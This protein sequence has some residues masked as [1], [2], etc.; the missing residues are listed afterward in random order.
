MPLDLDHLLSII[1]CVSFIS[2][3]ISSALGGTGNFGAGT[4]ILLAKNRNRRRMSFSVHTGHRL[5]PHRTAYQIKYIP[6]QRHS[7]KHP[8]N[9]R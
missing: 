9:V 5:S 4:G 3:T 2:A 8:L 1:A 6:V 7:K